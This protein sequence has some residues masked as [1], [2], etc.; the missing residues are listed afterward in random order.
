MMGS[1][2]VQFR[3]S[4]A[5]PWITA[6]LSLAVLIVP[7]I[8]T[9]QA[10]AEAKLD[11]KTVWE[12]LTYF[13]VIVAALTGWLRRRLY[14]DAWFDTSVAGA[15][16][17]DVTLTLLSFLVAFLV[18][19]FAHRTNLLGSGSNAV[20]YTVFGGILASGGY[21]LFKQ[22]N[23]DTAGATKAAGRQSG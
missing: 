12:G 23:G 3:N 10:V 9:G 8:W 7:A 21:A 19:Q 15:R 14:L 13:S 5:Y 22:I 11:L 1:L 16:A 18:Y 4:G 20:M 2:A 17:K 6:L